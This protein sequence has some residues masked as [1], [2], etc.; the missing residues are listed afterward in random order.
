MFDLIQFYFGSVR[1]IK[2]YASNQTSLFKVPDIVSSI[3]QFESGVHGMGTW[4]FASYDK[5]DITE[6]VGS[7]GK[8]KYSTF[9]DDPFTLE[10]GGKL[11]MIDIPNPEHVQQP[12]IQTI[13]DELTGIGRCPS[14][15]D[16]AAV[17]NL[18]MDKIILDAN[19]R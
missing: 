6:I 14:T 19:Y 16:T 1:S 10:I 18:L 15:G 12:L 9:G 4:G 2:G 5:A 3:F 7:K 11:E 8:I 13:V 17:T